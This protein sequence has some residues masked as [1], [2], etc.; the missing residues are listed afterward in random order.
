MRIWFNHWFSTAVHLIALL[1]QDW[2]DVEIIGSHP[3][4]WAAYQYACDRW[5]IEPDIQGQV[6]A[7]W[8]LDFAREQQ[9]D[10]F[11]PWQGLR[12]IAAIQNEFTAAGIKVLVPKAGKIL[13]VLSD[14][15]ATYDWLKNVRPELVPPYC[16]ADTMEEFRNALSDMARFFPDGRACYKL[17]V[18]E[19]AS[20]FRVVD[21]RIESI[22]ALRQMPGAKV[23][24]YAAEH[25]MSEYDFKV[26]VLVMP[27]LM[28]CIEISRNI[29]APGQPLF[30]KFTLDIGAC[31]AP[32]SRIYHATGIRK[33]GING[34]LRIRLTI[35][36]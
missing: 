13:S 3:Q 34:R 18:D 21:D 26:P 31:R 33:A 30:N 27:Y 28:Q 23:T 16:A 17:A 36:G 9:V 24:R 15:A 25:I 11:V 20:S 32:H 14:K 12:D 22:A 8:C 5:G 10:V 29:V 19:G 35:T 2:G 6:Y 1:R 4:E 7:F